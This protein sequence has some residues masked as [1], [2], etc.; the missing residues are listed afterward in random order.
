MTSRMA[1]VL[2]AAGLLLVMLT[3]KSIPHFAPTIPRIEDVTIDL[4]VLG[5]TLLTS[6]AVGLA[7][8]VMPALGA[9]RVNLND[10][11]KQGAR[12]ASAW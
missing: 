4:R 12:G 2:A 7:F 9:T 5:F 11:L 10:T 8:G 6:L 3:L 1:L